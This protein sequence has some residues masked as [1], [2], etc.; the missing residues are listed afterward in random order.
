[1]TLGDVETAAGEWR[2]ER[3]R[4]VVNKQKKKTKPTTLKGCIPALEVE[5]GPAQRE[6][7]ICDVKVSFQYLLGLLNT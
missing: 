7:A 2:E 3:T 6:T 5:V 1:M 4:K